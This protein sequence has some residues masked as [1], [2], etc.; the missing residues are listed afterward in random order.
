MRH[1]THPPARKFTELLIRKLPIPSSTNRSAVDPRKPPLAAK[2][3]T[4]LLIRKSVEVYT[5]RSAVHAQKI[6]R[7][8]K[9]SRIFFS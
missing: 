3:S 5:D 6:Y 9:S 1:P 7:I 4:E 2:K 8:G